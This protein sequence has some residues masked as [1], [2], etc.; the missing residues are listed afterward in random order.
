MYNHDVGAK[1]L[2]KVHCLSVVLTVHLSA[3][4]PDQVLV[5]NLKL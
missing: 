1:G 3:G 4:V 5:Y 2:N